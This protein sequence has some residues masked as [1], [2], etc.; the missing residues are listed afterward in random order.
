MTREV[1]RIGAIRPGT[2]ILL[3]YSC[4]ADGYPEMLATA[5]NLPGLGCR[6]FWDGSMTRNRRQRD[7]PADRRTAFRFPV[8]GE[9]SEGRLQ[10]GNGEIDVQVV[11]ESAGGFA[12]EFEGPT[13]CRVGDQ[14]FLGIGDE[15]VRVRI[16]FLDMQDVGAERFSNCNLVSQTRLG[17]KRVADENWNPND[18]SKKHGLWPKFRLPLVNLRK[19]TLWKAAA[20]FVIGLVAV[21]G[22]LLHVTKRSQTFDPIAREGT[23]ARVARIRDPLD[24]APKG[25]LSLKRKADAQMRSLGENAP[26]PAQTSGGNSH[27]KLPRSQPRESSSA[28]AAA[29]RKAVHAPLAPAGGGTAAKIARSKTVSRAGK[30]ATNFIEHALELSEATIRIAQ[31]DVLLSPEMV[32]R[33]HLSP[34]QQL[35]L[36]RLVLELRTGDRTVG[37][38]SEYD[39]A[40]LALGRRSLSILTSEQRKLLEAWQTTRPA[41]GKAVE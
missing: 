39:T 7:A 8:S 9:R 26:G 18:K 30:Q 29:P 24:L 11:D 37:S 27:G 15:W 4:I 23:D 3:T 16:V 14:L 21:G 10:W 41:D 12:V 6:T 33:L 20:V 2:P 22:A 35:Q 34:A 31:P 28:T 40:Q 38:P 19:Q 13:D 36:Q 25:M 1:R 17:L 5:G 32:A